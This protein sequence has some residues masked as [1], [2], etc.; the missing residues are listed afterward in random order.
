MAIWPYEVT[1]VFDH[2]QILL[3]TE[4]TIQMV[5]DMGLDESGRSAMIT[6]NLV[7][8]CYS[9]G[10][11][12]VMSKNTKLAEDDRE[13]IMLEI[14]RES[15]SRWEW[16]SSYCK[17]TLNINFHPFTLLCTLGALASAQI[18]DESV[19]NAN[20]ALVDA[21]NTY[22]DK[23]ELEFKSD[24]E[25]V[26]PPV[27]DAPAES[28]IDLDKSNDELIQEYFKLMLELGTFY[29]DRSRYKTDHERE[30]HDRIIAIHEKI[31][32]T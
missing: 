28:Q 25:L 10:I 16:I 19:Q 27:V 23:M 4:Q 32:N 11:N 24:L 8:L 13:R 22:M 3:A 17:D 20:H 30:L 29:R 12:C 26:N 2:A 14:V 7:Q 18:E 15:Q 31:T 21:I 5:T 1:D 6:M 9:Q